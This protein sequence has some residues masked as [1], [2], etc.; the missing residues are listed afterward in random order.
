MRIIG[1][2]FRGRVLKGPTTSA[3]RP[4]SDRL[5]ETLFNILDHSYDDPIREANILDIFAGTGAVAC[6]ALSRGAHFALLIEENRAA[7]A[8]IS[9]NLNTLSL[10]DQAQIL[11][12]DARRLG[13][14]TR[15]AKF[16]F[17]FLDPPYG[18]GLVTPV[19]E[20]LHKNGWLEPGALVV[21]EESAETPLTLPASYKPVE[22]RTYGETQLLF[23][24]Y[25]EGPRDA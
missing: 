15:D 22:T 12:R 4:T 10:T 23:A 8:L 9:A 19:L 7:Q 2:R 16:G 1:G 6:E 13:P 11:R 24:R 3:I 25:Q 5:R 14:L 21:I 20:S 18:Q 17:A